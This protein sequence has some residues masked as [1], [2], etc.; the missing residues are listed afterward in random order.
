M[1]S[2]RILIMLSFFLIVL[3]WFGIKGFLRRVIG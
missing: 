1:D 3:T 2:W